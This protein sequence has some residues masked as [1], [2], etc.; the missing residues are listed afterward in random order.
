[1]ASTVT[2]PASP[3]TAGGTAGADGG[4]PP[5]PVIGVDGADG[6]RSSSAAAGRLAVGARAAAALGPTS[7]ADMADKAV[8]PDTR[9]PPQAD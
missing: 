1:M 4:R 2:S 5:D 7:I 9:Q 3:L 6:W 8:N